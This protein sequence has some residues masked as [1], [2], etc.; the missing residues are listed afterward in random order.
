MLEGGYIMIVND[1][2]FYI[3]KNYKKFEDLLKR[4]QQED[5]EKK[6]NDISLIENLLDFIN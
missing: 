5:F 2:Y 6:E 4:L 1:L 3:S